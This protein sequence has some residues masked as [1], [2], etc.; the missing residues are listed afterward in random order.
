MNSSR[1][2][3]LTSDSDY[4]ATQDHIGLCETQGNREV[5]QDAI[6]VCTDLAVLKTLAE[7]QAHA[8][9]RQTFNVLQKQHGKHYAYAGAAGCAAIA[10]RDT[11]QSLLH[12]YTGNLGDCA[13]YLILL[14]HEGKLIQD[15]KRRP[16][17]R[18][19]NPLHNVTLEM[20][21]SLQSPGDVP[22][23]AGLNLAKGF[24]D[25]EAVAQGF[26]H[27]PSLTHT[28]LD[29][30][31]GYRA[32]IVVACDGL[33]ENEV[34]NQYLIGGIVSSGVKEGYNEEA[35]AEELVT[36]AFMDGSEDNVSACVFEITDKVTAAA[37]FDGHGKNAEKLTQLL[38]RDF[39]PTL[40]SLAAMAQEKQVDQ[41]A[42][43]QVDKIPS[44]PKKLKF[45]ESDSSNS[46]KKSPKHSDHASAEIKNTLR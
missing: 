11:E 9:I 34:L 26:S 24:G 36:V 13:A 27:H 19:L 1:E 39:F 5:Q 20:P 21:G 40:Q 8:V 12:V 42:A 22:R 6:A 38:A 17:S 7:K 29:I 15:A 45:I 46:P 16:W 33:T 2:F 30:E 41:S 25:Q 35:I 23:R 10:W 43:K 3:K 44:S 32:F 37:V 18:R 28:K 31:K 14:D 4:V